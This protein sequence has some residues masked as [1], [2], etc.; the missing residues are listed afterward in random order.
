MKC[1]KC[2]SPDVVSK[3]VIQGE[4]NTDELKLCHSCFKN[5]VKEHPAVMGGDMA[6]S[7]GE[8]LLGTI[9]YLN[10]SLK[11]HSRNL[12]NNDAGL[13]QCPNCST[14]EIRIKKD[15]ITGCP[16][17]Y[18]FFKKEI[19]EYLLARIGNNTALSTKS[20]IPKKLA[21]EELK[22][23]LVTAVKSENYEMAALIRDELKKVK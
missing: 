22:N 14:P 23:K 10:N 1:D 11:A 21:A 7:L 8:I 15:G 18:V 4:K 13:R 3:I 5:F 9:Q 19:D 12:V 16:K 2:G 6:G 17:C 20:S